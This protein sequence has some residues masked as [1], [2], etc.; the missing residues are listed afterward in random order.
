MTPIPKVFCAAG[1]APREKGSGADP[2]GPGKQEIT[3]R[4]ETPGDFF[5]LEEI[6]S[7]KERRHQGLFQKRKKERVGMKRKKPAAKKEGACKI[8]CDATKFEAKPC[9][10][11][12]LLFLILKFCS[13]PP[14]T[15]YCEMVIS[16]KLSDLW[17]EGHS[18]LFRS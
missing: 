8:Q 1:A 10:V 16:R 4:M 5:K 7:G 17:S 11:Y 12:L 2:E 15:R 3:Q 14:L 9:V 18:V 13:P 6:I